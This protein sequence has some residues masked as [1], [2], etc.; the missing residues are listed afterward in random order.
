VVTL[1]IGVWK[2]MSYKKKIK[3]VQMNRG[4]DYHPFNAMEMYTHHMM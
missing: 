3:V 4:R 1:I 2:G